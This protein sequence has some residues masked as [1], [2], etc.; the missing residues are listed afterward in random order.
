MVK[1]KDRFEFDF[2]QFLL[3]AAKYNDIYADFVLQQ[4][5]RAKARLANS[6]AGTAG[7]HCYTDGTKYFYAFECPEGCWQASPQKGKK[8]SEETKVK[9]S[10]VAKQRYQDPA[11]REKISQS[12]VGSKGTV[13]GKIWINDGIHERYIIA[14]ANLP[15]GWV[16]GRCPKSAAKNR[17]SWAIGR[18][19]YKQSKTI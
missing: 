16:R 13:I 19:V 14:T 15:E 8:V 12:K 4:S 6:K 18:E 5:E 1:I 7:K 11:L 2:D 9:M 17:Q 10:D 3:E